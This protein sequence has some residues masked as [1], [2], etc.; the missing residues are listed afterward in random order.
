MTTDCSHTTTNLDEQM[1][2]LTLLSLQILKLLCHPSTFKLHQMR[3]QDMNEESVDYLV[4][5]KTLTVNVPRRRTFNGGDDGIDATPS[6][7]DKPPSY[8]KFVHANAAYDAQI[9]T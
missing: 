7:S 8:E 2:T 6:S 4:D 9:D 5:S 3:I 1:K